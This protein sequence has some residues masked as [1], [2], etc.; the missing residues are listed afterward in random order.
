MSR[1]ARRIAPAE[2]GY[3]LVPPA[4]LDLGAWKSQGLPFY[5]D[6]VAYAR[7]FR[8][9]AGAGY[10]VRLGSRGPPMVRPLFVAF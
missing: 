10:V 6:R 8:L 2:R 3:R 4:A 5:A 7:R 1:A 9:A